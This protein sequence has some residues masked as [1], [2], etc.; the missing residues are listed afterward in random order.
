MFGPAALHV[1]DRQGL[2]GS[3]VTGQAQHDRA[4]ALEQQSRKLL[5]NG[6][7]VASND[8]AISRRR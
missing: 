3:A 4:R 6:T 1:P 7:D 5:G 2:W 8:Y